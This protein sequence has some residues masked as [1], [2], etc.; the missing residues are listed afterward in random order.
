[1]LF[2]APLQGNPPLSR[3]CLILATQAAPWRALSYL[4][5]CAVCPLC[6]RARR[7]TFMRTFPDV[8]RL[9]GQVVS[10]VG[11]FLSFRFFPSFFRSLSLFS[12]RWIIYKG[13]N[14][15]S[16]LLQGTSPKEGK[17][18]LQCILG[19]PWS[20]A[21]I[22]EFLTVWVAQT[23]FFF[24]HSHKKRLVFPFICPLLP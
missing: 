7:V 18:V 24:F 16:A 2:C 17:H 12:Q 19:L 8:L 21:A 6:V 3:H 20:L 1:M 9:T 5:H 4:I 10:S 22:Q 13:G 11:I 15:P 14:F 23:S